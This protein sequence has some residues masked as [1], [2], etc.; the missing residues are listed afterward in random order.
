MYH[1]DMR[2][3]R[4]IAK[5]IEFRGSSGPSSSTRNLLHRDSSA[6]TIAQALPRDEMSLRLDH[7][8]RNGSSFAILNE[9][10]ITNDEHRKI[11]NSLC[12]ASTRT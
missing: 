2:R 10:E 11:A 5:A 8:A 7:P 3:Y 1:V 12:R 6:A 4:V 9:V